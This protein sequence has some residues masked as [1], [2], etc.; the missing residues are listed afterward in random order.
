MAQNPWNQM[1]PQLM[2]SIIMQKV[3]QKH[4]LQTMTLQNQQAEQIAKRNFLAKMI[5]KESTRV[6]QPMGPVRDVQPGPYDTYWKKPGP[7]APPKKIPGYEWSPRTEKY[8]KVE[9]V[10]GKA[11]AKTTPTAM[12]DY[13]WTTYGKEVPELR[14]TK[15]YIQGR[16]R[17]KRAATKEGN[18]LQRKIS[19]I[20]KAY[21]TME[22][23]DVH[24]LAT[25]MRKV[26]VDPIS[27]VPTIVD[28]GTGE[29]RYLKEQPYTPEAQAA[30]GPLPR[31][32]NLWE[33]VE[34]GTGLASGALAK[35]SEISGLVRGPVAGEHIRARQD[36][37]MA[38]R[39]LYSSLRQSSK[40]LAT[41]MQYIFEQ[42]PIGPDI[43][44][45]PEYA[46]AQ[47]RS[48]DQAVKEKLVRERAKERDVRLPANDRRKARSVISSMES[49]LETLGVPPEGTKA[50]GLTQ[51]DN[52]LINKYLQ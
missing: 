17:W 37:V 50:T 19:G 31:K 22:E 51:E 41:E 36:L 21:P 27:G 44:K 32:I 13:E 48:I 11:K 35:G 29:S 43:F 24:K 28:L 4:Q 26:V 25:G 15:E 8:Y 49:F 40:V 6:G 5:P 34:K 10:A 45:S 9:G 52:D 18:A 14:G 2:A 12:L 7:E 42:F 47:F 39:Q 20:R 16:N 30:A 33:S 3:G 1:L 46:K 23:E 38:Q